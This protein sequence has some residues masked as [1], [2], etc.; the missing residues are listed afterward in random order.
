MIDTV[1]GCN[2]L[3]GII[4]MAQDVES[5]YAG[6]KALTCVVRSNRAAQAEM[7]R[8]RCY[9]TLGMFFKK[10]K[11]LLNS[12]ILHLTFGL[13]GTVNSGQDMSSIPNVTAFQDLLCDLEIWH[14]APNG[15]LR[16]LL[17]HLLELVVESSDKKQNI[18]I[19]RDLQ[20]LV[21]LLHIITQ[22][23]DH[24]TRE[25]LFNLLETLLG[26]QPRHTDLLLFG[27]YVAA[28]LPLAHNGGLERA[29]LLP[30]MKNPAED[31]DGGVAQNIYL[32]NR[33]LSLLHGLLFTPRNTVN[34]VICDD[35]SKTLGMDWLLLFMQPHV[36][37]TTVIIAVRIL[38]VICA[39][40]SFLVRFRDAT[41]NGG[42]LRFTEMVSQRK[43][44]GLGAQ[45]LNQRPT[46]GT[47]TVIV[48]TPQN[49]IQH[50]PTQIAGEVRAAALNI[51]GEH[52]TVYLQLSNIPN[53]LNVFQVFNFLNGL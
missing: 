46:N 42:Y 52:R 50:L 53:N 8:K 4:A 24:S 39:N 10:K 35:I 22:I 12:H 51:P 23:Q 18:K 17:E 49:T 27:Q 19:M 21:K 37:F 48:A 20:L 28:K 36:H 1:G 34:Y 30:S 6:V 25:I 47:G 38:V 33:C 14:N 13:V 32:R 9:Q 11:H 45:Q 7:D 3:L 2:V 29:V 31:Q 40:E 26:G 44:M 16:S 43:M 41:H 15:L 5:L